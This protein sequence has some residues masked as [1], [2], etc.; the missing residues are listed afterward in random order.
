[1]GERVRQSDVQKVIAGA[2]KGGM[3]ANSFRIEVDVERGRVL[4]FPLSGNEA[5][6]DEDDLDAEIRKLMDG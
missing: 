5:P 1:M 4:I 3:P 6:A 2:I